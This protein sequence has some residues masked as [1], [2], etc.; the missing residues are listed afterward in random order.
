MKKILYAASRMSHI[1]N[2]HLPYIDYFKSKGDEVHVLTQGSGNLD[3]DK[4]YDID[5]EK[6]IMSFKNIRTILKIKKIL[7]EE[8]YDLIITNT[9]LCSFL[10]RIAKQISKVKECGK[11]VNIVHGYLFSNNTKFFKK[12]IYILVEKICKKSTDRLLT[13]NKEDYEIAVKY[14]LCNY[15]IFNINGMGIPKPPTFSQEVRSSVRS[16]YSVDGDEILFT[17]IGELSKRKNQIFLFEKIEQISK[18]FPK[19][20]LILAGNGDLY[21]FYKSEIERLKISDKIILAGHVN[22]AKELIYSSDIIISSS[23][24][25][26]LPFNIMEAMSI[27]IPV[28]AS[29]IKG[30]ID[31]IT[32]GYNG[33]LFYL[34]KDSFANKLNSLKENK[35][36]ENLKNNEKTC[37]KKFMLDSIFDDNIK[38]IDI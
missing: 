20:K 10:V 23:K 26:G 24:S 21:D 36:I 31:L 29:R 9:T 35:D 33:Y 32:D 38:L 11:L 8:K 28:I 7:E 30:H 19:F 27:G 14:C 5:F 16:F 15:D 22:N 4:I 1:T 25:E 17:Y 6:K 34:D 12:T 18:V 2:F 13:M 3:V 37:I